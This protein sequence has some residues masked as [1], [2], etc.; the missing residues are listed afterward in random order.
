M[1]DPRYPGLD[2]NDLNA[3]NRDMAAAAAGADM[4]EGYVD[5]WA[6]GGLPGP[7]A[8]R[9]AMPIYDQ[10]GNL[11]PEDLVCEP[12]LPNPFWNFGHWG[13]GPGDYGGGPGA[14][15]A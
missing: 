13:G 5:A 15:C 11:V 2:N 8:G 3:L 9:R 10:N 14:G 7:G 4:G 12:D 1:A 6:F